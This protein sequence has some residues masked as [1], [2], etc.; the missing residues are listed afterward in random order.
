MQAH[1]LAYLIQHKVTIGFVFGRGQGLGTARNLYGI[2]VDDS[3]AA[4]ELAEGE[5]KAIIE[6][7]KNN[8]VALILLAGRI[9]VEDFLHSAE[10]VSLAGF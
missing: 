3:D 8:C 9:K 7:P 10:P 1:G 4:E 6:T 2:R 5:F